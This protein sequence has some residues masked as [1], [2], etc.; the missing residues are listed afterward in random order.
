MIKFQYFEDFGKLSPLKKT[1][2]LCNFEKG[3]H[4]LRDSLS[5]IFIHDYKGAGGIRKLCWQIF[6]V[7]ISLHF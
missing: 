6:R 4:F 5:Y 7:V 3:T 1:T 2:V